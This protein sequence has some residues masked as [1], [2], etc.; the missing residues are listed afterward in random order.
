M[1]RAGKREKSGL[2]LVVLIIICLAV[3]GCA[4]EPEVGAG[5]DAVEEDI[6]LTEIVELNGFQ[7]EMELA[8]TPE[9]REQGLMGREAL[10]DDRGMLFVLPDREPYPAEVSFWMK[11]CLIPID[12]IFISREGR[13]TAIH[14]MQPPEPGT[15][16][17][18]LILY[19]SRGKVQFAIELRG[20]L[21]G[22]LGL[23]VGDAVELEKDY[24][25]G[26][27]E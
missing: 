10:A 13:I 19:P 4:A 23:A 5:V 14:E 18:D 6:L 2:T 17:E 21:A 1:F 15:A 7:V 26:L 11:D 25:L 22:E 24:L 8:V 12:L 3:S 20:G 9:Q 16:D 27:A